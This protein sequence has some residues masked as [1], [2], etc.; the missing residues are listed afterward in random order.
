MGEE[1]TT[2]YRVIESVT[3]P[4]SLDYLIDNGFLVPVELVKVGGTYTH[5]W[6]CAN[7]HGDHGGEGC[8]KPDFGA[9]CQWYQIDDVAGIDVTDA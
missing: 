5:P 6:H 4:N 1:R 7:C 2:L 9:W 3:S 8:D